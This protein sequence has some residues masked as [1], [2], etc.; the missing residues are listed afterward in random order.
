MAYLNYNISI[1]THT[2]NFDVRGGA[3]IEIGTTPN[4]ECF[5]EA[6]WTLSISRKFVF[7]LI[8]FGNDTAMRISCENVSFRAGINSLMTLFFPPYIIYNIHAS[9]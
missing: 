7:W 2:S 5:K 9:H 4:I 6:Q 3:T 8:L 1:K